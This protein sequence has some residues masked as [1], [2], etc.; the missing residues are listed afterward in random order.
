[1]AYKNHWNWQQKD[2]PNFTY[3]IEKTTSLENK[4]LQQAGVSLG[5]FKH[6][7]E[8]ERQDIII[9]F[10]SNEAMNT[11]QIEGEQLDRSSLQSSIKRQLGLKAPSTPNSPAENGISEMM[12]N[13]YH[14]YDEP[15]SHEILFQ[16]HAMLMNGRRDIENIGKYR[17]HEDAMQIVSGADYKR[18]VHFEAPPS[19][20]VPQEMEQF[21]LWFNETSPQ[22]GKTLPPL[23]RAAIAH[24]YFESIHPFEDGNG[25]IGRA[26][27]EKALSQSLEQPAILALSE[28]INQKKSEYY[29]ELSDYSRTNHIDGWIT[30]F[31]QIIL[32]AQQ[33]SIEQI[34]FIIKK[35]QFM[36]YNEGEMN[37]RQAKAILRIF[38]AGI[39]GFKGGLSAKNYMTI[40][41]APSTT[42]TRDLNDLVDKK[43]LI[44]TGSLKATRYWLNLGK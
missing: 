6:I 39:E 35:D 41:N 31:S 7:S 12:I 1:M 21:I 44:K 16:W 34:E 4:F 10:M 5:V 37:L 24:L 23:I 3:S 29:K 26:L 33:Y 22:G 36:R 27:A 15:L 25:R 42:A 2:W 8:D 13:L 14:H 43:I 40:T 11:S 19:N 17:A 18:K 38:D 28:I 30:Y 32:K 9:R 20:I